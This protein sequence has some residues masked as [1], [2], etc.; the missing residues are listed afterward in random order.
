MDFAI[1]LLKRVFSA[2]AEVFLLKANGKVLVK[3]FLR[4]SGGVSSIDELVFLLT[5]F[6]AQAEVFLTFH[7]RLAPLPSF[8]RAS[9]GVSSIR[10]ICTAFV[11]FSPRKR[12]CF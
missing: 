6:S 4:A 5:V 7:R 12:R 2:Q 1:L 9:G 11:L 10:I 3:R 8:L